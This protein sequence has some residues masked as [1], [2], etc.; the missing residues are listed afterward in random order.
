MST[1]RQSILPSYFGNSLCHY[2]CTDLNTDASSNLFI[3]CF[4]TISALIFSEGLNTGTEELPPKP[5]WIQPELM[6]IQNKAKYWFSVC[7]R[8]WVIQPVSECM[9]PAFPEAIS[10]FAAPGK[11]SSEG[12]MLAPPSCLLPLYSRA[13]LHW[14]LPTE[15]GNISTSSWKL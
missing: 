9:P 2:H 4:F 12:R 6:N 14:V 10:S 15:N 8:A 11:P 3:Y 5:K 1:G 7:S 13:A